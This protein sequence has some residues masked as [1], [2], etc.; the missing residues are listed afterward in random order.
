MT[1]SMYLDDA[2]RSI[3][4]PEAA[5]TFQQVLRIYKFKDEPDDWRMES[6]NVREYAAYAQVDP[7]TTALMLKA[8]DTVN[9]SP[10]LQVITR[11][12][13][14]AVFLL[15]PKPNG[16]TWVSFTK[17]MPPELAGAVRMTIMLGIVRLIRENHKRE[18]VPEEYTRSTCAVVGRGKNE[19]I[20]SVVGGAG[21]YSWKQHFT[22]APL[23][24]FHIKRFGF[25]TDRY[26]FHADV[27]KNSKTH[28][29]AIFPKAGIRFDRRGFGLTTQDS[30]DADFTARFYIEDG[31]AVG[32]RVRPDGSAEKEL[33]RVPL[34]EFEPFITDNVPVLDMHIPGGGGM[35]PEVSEASFRAAKK[36]YFD[37][38]PPAQHPR[39]IVCWSW[40]FNPNLPEVLPPEANLNKLLKRVHLMPVSSGPTDG[41]GFVFP[42]NA[43][44]PDTAEQ[45][46]SLQRA[47][48]SYI[49]K[50]GR[51]RCGS[52]FID[53]DEIADC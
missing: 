21:A 14:R 42:K 46:T 10:A 37:L 4:E 6:E 48:M 12:H 30:P 11:S 28:E 22:D 18:N 20:E 34:D 13:F 5:E 17:C 50:G 44:T 45:R 35:T 25:M 39:A 49:R 1:R 23:H 53:M 24:Y 52:M 33:S 3:G 27:F 2:L 26:K 51:W 8:A 15:G 32:N 41:L 16:K 31:C 9:A 38:L 7:E 29:Y 47:I 40:I 19:P 36:C 43:F